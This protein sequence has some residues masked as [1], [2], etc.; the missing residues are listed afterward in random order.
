MTSHSTREVAGRNAYGAIRSSAHRARRFILLLLALLA[1]GHGAYAAN[2]GYGDLGSF[3]DVYAWPV[4][5]LN[6]SGSTHPVTGIL[7]DSSTSTYGTPWFWAASGPVL[8]SGSPGSPNGL[9]SFTGNGTQQLLLDFS[10]DPIE[11]GNFAWFWAIY[12]DDGIPLTLIPS[13]AVLGVTAT[14]T[15]SDSSIWMGVFTSIPPE[16]SST[17]PGGLYTLREQSTVPEPASL[18]LAAMSLALLFLFRRKSR[19]MLR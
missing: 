17:F 19:K 2:T 14:F 15:F 6:N 9:T 16:P 8:D 7:L 18:A 5:L 11:P 1:G 4:H 12:P 13:S 3:S 10:G